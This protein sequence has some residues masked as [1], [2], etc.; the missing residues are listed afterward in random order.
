MG[1]LDHDEHAL[2][3]AIWEWSCFTVVTR[4]IQRW[5]SFLIDGD[6]AVGG[7]KPVPLMTNLCVGPAHGS[8]SSTLDISALDGSKPCNHIST[9]AKGSRFISDNVRR[10]PRNE[11]QRRFG[12]DHRAVRYH[13]FHGVARKDVLQARVLTSSHIL[14]ERERGFTKTES[15]PWAWYR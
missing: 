13:L 4:S 15:G 7:K 9:I 2:R 12:A 3:R 5:T 6:S 1:R 11:C 14:T 8:Q 10:Q